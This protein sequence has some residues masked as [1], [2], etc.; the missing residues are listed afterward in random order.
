[1]ISLNQG[2]LAAKVGADNVVLLLNSK[3]IIESEMEDAKIYLQV[4][5]VKPH[6]EKDVCR[7]STRYPFFF[8]F[9]FLSCI[10]AWFTLT[11]RRFSLE[12][13]EAYVVRAKFHGES[14]HLRESFYYGSECGVCHF[15]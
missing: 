4:I 6:F 5:D 7:A 10:L 9:F 2:Y 15:I 8:A 13:F 12:G 14:I 11:I 1:L 3:K